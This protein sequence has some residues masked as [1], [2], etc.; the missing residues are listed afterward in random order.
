MKY[1]EWAN[2]ETESRLEATGH[3]G[4]Q[5]AVEGSRRL[6]GEELLFEVIKKELG[7][8]GCC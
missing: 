3:R 2:T 6:T 8:K 7:N 4:R 5:E 1:L